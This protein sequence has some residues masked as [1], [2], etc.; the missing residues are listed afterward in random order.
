[1]LWATSDGEMTEAG[2]VSTLFDVVHLEGAQQLAVYGGN[3][4]YAGRPAFSVNEWGEGRVYYASAIPDA[5]ATT[6][7]AQTLID[8]LD[9]EGIETHD[10]V[11]APARVSE[12]GTTFRFYLNTVGEVRDVAPQAGIDILTGTA[13][14][15][16]TTLELE[17][18][19]VAII[20]ED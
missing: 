9:I 19:G 1:M 3:E 5:A 10:G 17:P 16:E 15:P 6:R 2:T 11:F 7:I 18:Y 8:G 20:R 13:T 14:D 4:F 12:D